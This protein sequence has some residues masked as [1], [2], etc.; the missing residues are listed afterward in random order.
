MTDAAFPRFKFHLSLL[1]GCWALTTTC[2]LLLVT[3]SSLA[4]YMLAEEKALAALPIAL[5]WLA[6]AAFT[7]PA[8][9]IMRAWGRRGG[10]YLAVVLI[11]AGAGLAIAA[12]YGG[13]FWLFVAASVLV[14]MGS[15]NTWYYR[16][17]ATEVSPDRYKARAIAW[18]LMG[19]IFAAV[20]GPSLASWTKD[21]LS[22]TPF[23]G[24]F[25]AILAAQLG[26]AFLLSF[27]RIPRP[28]EEDL[29]GGR[30]M[31]EIAKQPKFI[32]AVMGGVIAYGIMVLLMSITPLAMGHHHH[33]FDAST[34]VI[35]WHVLGMYIPSLFSG[36]L[37]RRFG[38]YPIMLTGGAAMLATGII[39]AI[40]TGWWY[41][42]S[43]LTLLGVGWNFLYVGATTLLTDTYTT[44]EKAKTQALNET[45]VFVCTAI[46]TFASGA[47]LEIYGWT[48]IVLATLVP[49]VLVMGGVAWLALRQRPA[50]A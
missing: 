6:T 7:A 14:G 3:V 19:G 8:S 42:W 41:F 49:I 24:V 50:T 11:S 1:S 17:A 29:K 33:G 10:F 38:I 47:M 22:P 48:T 18:V 46:G 23:A 35:R 34:E 28:P 21:M 9:F 44:A 20:A 5:Q 30:P 40:D 27:V 43:S 4:G 15:G 26:I 2:N 13:S 31:W 36:H 12:I 39:G 16:F 32:V 45:L 37:I 25:V